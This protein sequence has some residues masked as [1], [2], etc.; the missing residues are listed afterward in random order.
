MKQL[1]WKV[2]LNVFFLSRTTQWICAGEDLKWRSNDFCWLKAGIFFLDQKWMAEYFS[3]FFLNFS[4]RLFWLSKDKTVFTTYVTVSTLQTQQDSSGPR[5]FH[6]PQRLAESFPPSWQIKRGSCSHWCIAWSLKG[7]FI[8]TP[9]MWVVAIGRCTLSFQIG[10]IVLGL[11]S[12][13]MSWF[14]SGEFFFCV[15]HSGAE[16]LKTNH[17]PTEGNKLGDS[18]KARNPSGRYDGSNADWPKKQNCL[19]NRRLCLL[20]QWLSV[21]GT[22]ITAYLKRL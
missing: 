3:S 1:S 15:P 5:V 11:F 20:S 21:L 12:D 8:N 6:F 7:T 2:V 4:C 22:A 13:I 16:I 10:S 9:L 19:A 14:L 18:Q 17:I